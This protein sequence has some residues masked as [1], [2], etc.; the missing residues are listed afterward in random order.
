[1]T[2]IHGSSGI[3]RITFALVA[4]LL[5]TCG[6]TIAADPAWAE[7]DVVEITLTVA[8]DDSSPSNAVLHAE[9]IGSYVEAGGAIPA[10]T[11]S[12]LVAD[13]AGVALFA[14][15][16][17]QPAGGP[18]F[19]DVVWSD[20]PSGVTASGVVS[21]LPNDASDRVDFAGATASFLTAGSSDD[22]TEISKQTETHASDEAEALKTET[23]DPVS[24]AL[25]LL[26]VAS[27][28]V[29]GLGIVILVR[30]DRRSAGGRA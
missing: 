17:A 16:V 2:A 18:T 5:A 15:E 14:T 26:A 3:R 27:L 9:M 6:A 29:A 13:D 28:V 8:P 10:G 23:P 24:V 20:V 7:P 21:F 22:A 11:W 1:M 4:G 30:R 19:V 12:F 25:G